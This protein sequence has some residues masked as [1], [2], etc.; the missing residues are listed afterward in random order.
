MFRRARNVRKDGIKR[1]S[2]SPES[3]A[4]QIIDSCWNKEKKYFQVSSG[5]FN[6]FYCRDFGMCAESLVK[7]GYRKKVIQTLD[8]ALGHFK[9]HGSITTSIS[10]RGVCFDFPYYAADSLP[11]IIHALRVAGAKELLRKYRRFIEREIRF[12]D[13]EVVDKKTNLVRLDRHFS[14]MKDQARRSSSCYSNCM[15]FMLAEDLASLKFY[16][17]FDASKTRK[18]LL[19]NFWN[20]NY[21][22]DDADFSK[23]VTGDANTF[24]FW[25]GVTNQK[26]VFDLC[27]ASMESAGLT[28]PFPL[29]YTAKHDR[30]SRMHFSD[31]VSGGYERDTVWMHLGLCFLDVVARFDRNRFSKYMKQYGLLI[32][33][34]HN[35]LELYR[36]DGRPFSTFFYHSDE[37]MLWVSKWLVLKKS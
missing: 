34:H 23:V 19:A 9:E 5:H 2:G 3:I 32:E 13:R 31:L 6:E 18:S 11:F 15:L 25:C 12:Y 37:S 35:F 28:R 27:M 8:Y 4:K 21:F 24:P 17:P 16:S 1:Y 26:Q 36:A 22:Y 33:K 7:L 20:G 30:I 10:P 14:S 29:K